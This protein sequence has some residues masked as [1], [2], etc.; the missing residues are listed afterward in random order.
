MSEKRKNKLYLNIRS[1]KLVLNASLL[2]V[3]NSLHQVRLKLKA[4][5]ADFLWSF[6]G[7][8]LPQRN[9]LSP[10]ESD[11]ANVLAHSLHIQNNSVH[12]LIRVLDVFSECFSEL[13]LQCDRAENGMIQPICLRVLHNSIFCIALLGS[14]ALKSPS[15][16]IFASSGYDS[17]QLGNRDAL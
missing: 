10:H 16:V 2:L 15:N 13:K 17:P 14:A 8:L 6:G 12:C 11:M 7:S 3:V 1:V 9:I 5:L 4:A